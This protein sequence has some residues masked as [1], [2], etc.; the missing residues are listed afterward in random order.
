[1]TAMTR[2]ERFGRSLVLLAR[3]YR[4]YLDDAL[5]PYGLSEAS[6]LP[7]RYLARLGDDTRQ[8]EL[9]DVM[10]IEGPTLVRTLDHLVAAGWVERIEASDD[11]RARLVRLTPQGRE[12]NRKL[13]SVLAECRRRLLRGVDEADMDAAL[14]V[15]ALLEVRLAGELSRN[16]LES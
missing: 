9:A 10:N 8:G 12:L 16:P 14:R 2:H 4:R 6:A 5:K 15:F 7:I 1:M 11:R 3:L 13:G